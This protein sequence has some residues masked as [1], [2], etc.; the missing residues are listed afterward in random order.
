MWGGGKRSSNLELL[1]IIAMV[2]IV[3][4]HY[5]VNS[6]IT[7]HFDYANITPNM[8]FLQLWGMWGKTAINIFVM[9]TG[10]FMPEKN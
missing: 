3:S 6:G 7:N 5:V 4:H 8:I 2:A 1:R 9:I 10:Y